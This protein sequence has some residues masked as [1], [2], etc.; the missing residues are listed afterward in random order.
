MLRF[1]NTLTGKKEEFVPLEKDLVRMYTCGPTVYANAHLGNMRAFV[2]QDILRRYLIYKGFRVKHVMNYTD[3]DD[4]TIRN[5]LEAKVSLR[6]YTDRYIQAFEIDSRL[7][8]L[9]T[10]EHRVRAT[11][12]I[13]DM[14]KM[15][16]GLLEKGHAY[17]AGGS[18]YFRVS[19]FPSYGR[20]SGIDVGGMKAGARVDVDEYDKENVRDFVLWKSGKKGEPCWDT[21]F[22]CGRPGWHIECSAMSMKYLGEHFD[23]HTG[24]T[25]LVFPHHENEIAQSEAL[26]GKPFVKTWL[27]AEHLLV[28]GQK[29]SKSSGNFYTL[30]DLIEN[31]HKPLPVRYLLASVP[32]RKQ[33]NFTFDALH[34]ATQS[35]ERLRNFRLRLKMEKFR[36]GE[37]AELTRKA[38]E[39]K[40]QFEEAMDDDLN[41][42]RALGAVFDLVREG[43]TAMDRSR[44]RLDN[45]K[46]FQETLHAWDRIFDILND[47]PKRKQQEAELLAEISRT[48]TAS[49]EGVGGAKVPTTVMPPTGMTDAEI[50][51]QL[52]ERE[53][54][55]HARDFSK[56]DRIRGALLKAGIVIED[57]KGGARWKRM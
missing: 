6:D 44:F 46:A 31:G 7:L 23:I 40:K 53:S 19:S 45:T 50:D 5:A 12:H 16:Q 41:T 20:L 18:I 38:Q 21:P 55:R 52:K 49:R 54:A 32:Y 33:L 37:D 28:N 13:E 30:R 26:T 29:M 15:V 11:D 10:P 2:F 22:G 47:D 36:A 42:A 34:Q 48:K 8:S 39:A 43:N 14:S 35:V 1:Y 25:D 9:E 27:H 17:E 56:A 57:T 4:K 24:G 51:A 3:V